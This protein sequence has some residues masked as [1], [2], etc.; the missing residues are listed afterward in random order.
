MTRIASIVAALLCLLAT[1]ALAKISA[2][3]VR[4]AVLNDMSGIYSDFQGPGSLLA[5]QMAVEDFGGKVAGMPVAVIAADHQNK[6]D[7]GVSIA[8]QWLDSDGVDAIVDVPNS[9]IA[10]AV[11]DIVREH[12][13]VFLVVGGGT[14]ALTGEKCSPN[15]VHWV[16]DTWADANAMARAGVRAGAKTWYFLTADYAFGYALEKQGMRA[17]TEEGGKVLGSIHVPLGAQDVSSFILQAQASKADAVALA[18]AGGDVTNAIRTAKEF[19]LMKG[20]QKIVAL[21]FQI[22]NVEALGTDTAQG[23]LTVNPFYWNLNDDTRSF[24]KRFQARDRKHAVPNEM[25][26]GV[27]SA[28]THYLKA[29]QALAG[30]ADGA[31]VVKKMKEM[32][33]DDPLFG[34]GYVRID[35]RKMHPMYLLQVKSPSES[36]GPWDYYKVLA[37]IPAE[38]A[39]RPLA[40]GHCPLVNAQ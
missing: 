37:S 12:N 29:L 34:K 21:I 9:A 18:S 28:V 26:A 24:A 31:S 4:I 5:A 23:I 30:K 10:L 40:E 3:T 38:E 2:G 39:F 25:H 32:P 11:N 19:G 6:P 16:Y 7:V 14:D 13:S 15:T 22:N 36:K 35:G 33:T 17:V 1:P 20:G 8:R 27:Y